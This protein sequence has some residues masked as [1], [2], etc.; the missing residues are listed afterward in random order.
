M[1]PHRGRH[2]GSDALAA[3]HPKRHTVVEVVLLLATCRFVFGFVLAM[4]VSEDGSFFL[5]S[6]SVWP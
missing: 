3:V 1:R 4:R 6:P 2:Q 5:F